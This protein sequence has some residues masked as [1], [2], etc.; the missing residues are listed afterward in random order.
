[1]SN[2]DD[3]LVQSVPRKSPT[4]TPTESEGGSS[5]DNSG[6]PP[7]YKPTKSVSGSKSE[8]SQIPE[9]L[10]NILDFDFDNR[11]LT[12]GDVFFDGNQG[13]D[14]G[15]DD[16]TLGWV[17]IVAKYGDKV[18]LSPVYS[19]TPPLIPKSINDMSGPA[20]ADV[21]QPNVTAHT[22][23]ILRSK[24]QGRYC[25][26]W[27]VSLASKTAAIHRCKVRGLLVMMSYNVHGFPNGKRH[28]LTCHKYKDTY[29]ARWCRL[30]FG[31]SVFEKTDLRQIVKSNRRGRNTK[32]NDK[33]STTDIPGPV[34]GNVNDGPCT[35]PREGRNVRMRSDFQTP[36]KGSRSV[37]PKLCRRNL[38][39]TPNQFQPD[40][41]KEKVVS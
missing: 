40:D 37:L 4:Y 35:P 3:N 19:P 27:S 11:E 15:L 24:I 29:K 21:F 17:E 7:A 41:S 5:D 39:T 25:W 22:G 14:S 23:R 33:G 8:N 13:E 2:V 12:V 9:L 34:C 26:E 28:T 18:Y 32:V 30:G 20:A 36:E 10:D 6:Q 38:F 16:Y 1:M 31:R